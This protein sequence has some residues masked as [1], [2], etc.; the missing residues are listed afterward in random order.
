MRLRNISEIE[1]FKAAID[2]CKG[3]FTSSPMMEH[4]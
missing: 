2:K 1:D 3:R 4:D